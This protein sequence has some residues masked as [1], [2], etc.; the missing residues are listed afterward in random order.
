MIA[1]SQQIKMKFKLVS[2]TRY[3][4][5]NIQSHLNIPIQIVSLVCNRDLKLLK[6]KLNIYCDLILFASSINIKRMM[7]I[8]LKGETE[9][10]FY[11]LN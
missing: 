1:F 6:C 2:L 8:K 3:F 9:D 5:F 4:Y 10:I 7:L 11:I